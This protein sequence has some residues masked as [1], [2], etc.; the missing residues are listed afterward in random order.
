M[1][2]LI[3]QWFKFD[4]ICTQ[5]ISFLYGGLKPTELITFKWFLWKSLEVYLD[6]NR[7]IKHKYINFKTTMSP[8]RFMTVWTKAWHRQ[9]EFFVGVVGAGTVAG[10]HSKVAGS[11][12]GSNNTFITISWV[13][14][15]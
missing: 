11:C 10:L 6:Y 5:D 2:L 14:K 8:D 12:H 1:K 7:G 4:C 9:L 15:S 3:C 13:K